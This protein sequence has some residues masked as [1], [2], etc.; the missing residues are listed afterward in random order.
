MRSALL[1]LALFAAPSVAFAGHTPVV[2]SGTVASNSIASGPFAG[3]AP[4]TPV[5]LSFQVTTP[6]VVISPN[7]Y[8]DY[9]I[10][11]ATFELDIGGAVA[12]PKPSSPPSLGVGNDFPVADGLFVFSAPLSLASHAFECECHEQTG[13]IFNS[14]DIQQTTGTY[15]GA[16]F[17]LVDWNVFGPGGQIGVVLN[18]VTIHPDIAS[19]LG[20]NYCVSNPNSSGFPA[21]IAASGCSSVGINAITLTTTQMPANKSALV[22]YGPNAIQTPFGAG[23]LCIGGGFNRLVPG[24]SNAIG[25]YA[26]PLNLDVPPASSGASQILP[27]STWRFQTWFRDVGGT[28][29]LSNATAI[30]FTL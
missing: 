26:R 12:G 13:T 16:L 29:S 23:V 10:D 22:F 4:G 7:Q 6:G 2:F 3:K 20:T 18:Q 8:E 17:S 25:V 21:L 14:I 5:R 11:L 19:S 28:T 15:S 24:A 9:T 1:S 27:G 30:T